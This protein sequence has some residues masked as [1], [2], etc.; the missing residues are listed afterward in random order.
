MSQGRMLPLVGPALVLYL[1]VE[2]ISSGVPLDAAAWVLVSFALAITVLPFVLARQEEPEGVRRLSWVAMCVAVGLVATAMPGLLS[3]PLE[4]A[5]ALAWPWVGSLVIDLALDTP[6]RPPG[7]ARARVIGAL[8]HAAALAAAC[9]SMLAVLPEIELFGDV[10]LVPAS[11]SVLAPIMVVVQLVTAL[12]VRLARRRLGSTPEALASNGGALLGIA[13]GAATGAAALIAV[14]IGAYDAGASVVRGL[15]CTGAVAILAGHLAMLDARRPIHAA[16]ASRRV[17]SAA[18]T[19]SAL[20]AVLAWLSDR[21]PSDRVALGVLSAAFVATAALVYRLIAAFVETLFAPDGGRLLRAIAE[22]ERASAG[23]RT[24]EEL[25]SA[26]LAPLRRA[27][28]TRDARPVIQTLEPAKQASVDAAGMPK[29]EARAMSPA[30]LER[31][32]DRPGEIIVLAPLRAMV[33]RR[34]DLRAL[35]DALEQLEALCVVPIAAAG[36]LE[37][38]L[39]VPRGRRRAPVTL[40]EIAALEALAMRLTGPLAMHQAEARAQDRAARAMA[41]SERLEERIDALEDELTRLRADT[42]TLKAGRAS[43]RLAAPAIAYSPAMR[44]LVARI[45][46]VA[47][48]DAPVQIVGEVGS[49]IDQI[50]HLVHAASPMRDGPFVI[51]D[52]AAIRPERTAAALF[53]D[54]GEAGSHPGWLRLAT[55]GTLLLIDVPA[56]SLETQAA[57]GEAIA[58]RSARAEGGAS[59]YPVDVRLVAHSRLEV[60]ALARV[61]AFDAELARRLE[62]LRLDVPPLRERREDLPS[63]VLLALD[64]ACRA[65]GREVLGIE[66]SAMSVLLAYEWPG[67]LRELQSVIDRAVARGSAPRVVESD[68]PALPQ[69]KVDVVASDPLDGTWTEIELRALRAALDRAGGNKSEAARLLGLK[70]TT[71]LD[72]MRRA[73]IEDP[74]EGRSAAE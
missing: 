33:V 11:A 60:N 19:A 20:G 10:L 51:A 50:A 49:P 35:V 53:G 9:V 71:F 29:V 66:E 59:A 69:P 28:R 30:L 4:L 37:G 63:L 72:K 8:A 23:T 74:G 25:A 21:L 38:A 41:Q 5:A 2:L 62:P 70:R 24:L 56:L 58:T 40:E 45:G 18:L 7:L 46:E 48:V 52:C 22:G 16:R 14:A 36:E 34:P 42:R 15:V 3:P 12:A 61:S 54:E 32:M 57:L 13:C 73:G 44:A 43:D 55:G 1:V 64:R 68:L 39:V 27:A 47:V 31:L 67:N 26:V 6:D 17:V 65:L